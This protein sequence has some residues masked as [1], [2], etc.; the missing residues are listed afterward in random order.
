MEKAEIEQKSAE[1]AVKSSH[2][3]KPKIH[4]KPVMSYGQL[5]TDC[6]RA[7]AWTDE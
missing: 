3:G 7:H 6:N 4:E 2:T 1:W 5:P